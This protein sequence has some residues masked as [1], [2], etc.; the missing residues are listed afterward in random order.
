[1]D[2]NCHRWIRASWRASCS[3]CM[4]SATLQVGV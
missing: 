3:I 1:M 4:L 2:I